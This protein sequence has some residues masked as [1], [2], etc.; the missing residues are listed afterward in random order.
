MIIIIIKNK[1]NFIIKLKMVFVQ[2]FICRFRKMPPV[3]TKPFPTIQNIPKS[4]I[5]SSLSLFVVVI[6]E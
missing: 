6:K 1:K 3:A 2:I 5:T 4:L